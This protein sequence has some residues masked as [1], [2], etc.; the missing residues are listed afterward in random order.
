VHGGD[1]E[2]IRWSEIESAAPSIAERARQRL[3][4]TRVALLGTLRGDGSPRISPVE[5]YF[6]HGHLLFGAMAWSLKTGDLRADPRCVLHSAITAPDAG[7]PEV[8]LY[9]RAIEVPTEIRNGCSAG[10]WQASPAATAVVF[11]LTV[12]RATVIEWDLEQSQMFVRRWSPRDG[13]TESS[14]SYP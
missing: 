6:S 10:W 2:G 3:E 8:K 11:S 5:P 9:G 13:L 12:E 4:A 1:K 7:E 14:R